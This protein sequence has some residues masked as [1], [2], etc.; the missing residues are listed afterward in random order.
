MP[1]VPNHK[2]KQYVL[3]RKP[4]LGLNIYGRTLRHGDYCVFSYT[5]RWPLYLHYRD[6]WYG[7]SGWYS[8]TSSRHARLLRPADNVIELPCSVLELFVLYRDTGFHHDGEA[9]A[10]V[11]RGVGF[12]PES[13][14]RVIQV[15]A[16]APAPLPVTTHLANAVVD[17]DA[18]HRR[19]VMP[20]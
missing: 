1:R 6:Q 5:D 3:D 10:S 18:V 19:R 12:V 17:W 9:L 15:P 8:S 20:V 7:N 4:F 2:A 16:P 11:L 13:E 14:R